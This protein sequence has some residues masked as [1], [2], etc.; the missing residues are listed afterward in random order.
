MPS[1]SRRVVR[2]FIY[3]DE[4]QPSVLLLHKQ[5]PT[6]G[7]DCWIIPGGG[8]G[9]TDAGPE[10][11][12]AAL[13]RELDE[14][15][16]LRTPVANTAQLVWSGDESFEWDGQ[17]HHRDGCAFTIKVPRFEPVLETKPSTLGCRWW[18]LLELQAAV[19][20]GSIRFAPIGAFTSR[21]DG[22][23]GTDSRP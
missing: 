5:D 9:D 22:A 3:S 2:A 20:E 12:L 17:L 1:A 10:D 21:F 14:E 19:R 13:E 8:V 16:G 11:D 23:E 15:L 4:S 18:P 7:A 6:T